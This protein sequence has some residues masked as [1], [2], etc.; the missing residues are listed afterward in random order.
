[1][2]NVNLHQKNKICETAAMFSC[3]PSF[4]VFHVF[5]GRGIL[6]I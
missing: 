6:F 3:D 2:A 1:M 4:Q 5:N